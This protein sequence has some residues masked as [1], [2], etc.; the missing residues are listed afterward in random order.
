[1]VLI[2]WP[3]STEDVF[4]SVKTADGDDDGRF[5]FS[6][7]APREY[8]VLAVA[9]EMIEKLDEPRV[10]SRLLG[11]AERVELTP[12]GSQTLTLKVTNPAR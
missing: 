5:Q 11:S 9:P 1:V 10:L 3:V 8:R 4:R 12:G 7:L 6:G 2:R